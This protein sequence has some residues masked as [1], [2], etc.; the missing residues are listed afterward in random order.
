MI[1]ESVRNLTPPEINDAARESADAIGYGTG[2]GEHD[3][4]PDGWEY[5]E[6]TWIGDTA[7]LGYH[8]VVETT[9]R[10]RRIDPASA[11]PSPLQPEDPRHKR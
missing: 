3:P 4:V 8:H 10:Y 6:T 1:S 11:G 2:L 7:A 9:V 5:T